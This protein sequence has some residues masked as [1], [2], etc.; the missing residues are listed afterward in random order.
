[1]LTWFRSL[2][3]FL[4]RRKPKTG[5]PSSVTVEMVRS[6]EPGPIPSVPA[7]RRRNPSP[8]LTPYL[9]SEQTVRR[10]MRTMKAGL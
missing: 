5:R 2:I 4:F 3:G 8:T 6:T 7:L 1:M 10:R 9:P